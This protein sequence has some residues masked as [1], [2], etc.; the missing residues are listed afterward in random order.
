MAISFQVTKQQVDQFEH[1]KV[2]P[3]CQLLAHFS[4]QKKN[5]IPDVSYQINLRGAK[6]P[7]NYFVITLPLTGK[8]SN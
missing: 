3:G 5:N 1:G 7:Y 6:S 4:S 2:P 8:Y